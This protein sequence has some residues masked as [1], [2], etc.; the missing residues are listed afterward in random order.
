MRILPC[1]TQ[2]HQHV[3]PDGADET[4]WFSSLGRVFEVEGTPVSTGRFCH[5]V[6]IRAGNRDYYVKRYQARGKHCRKALGRSRPLVEYRNLAYFARMGIP[7]P[8]VV[9]YGSQR[10]L[11]LFRRGAIVTEG[12][13]EAT[14]LETLVRVRPDLL[15]NRT[16]LLQVLRTLADYV[17][18]LHEDGLTH[19]DLKWRNILV[20]TGET[21]N[22]FFLDCP[23]GHHGLGLRREHF[24]VKDLANLDRLARQHLPRTM[25]LRFY[26]WYRNRT[27]LNRKDKRRIAKVVAFWTHRT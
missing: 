22:V 1:G 25:R 8:R 7:V 11:G 5:V 14:D 17:R 18:R 4:E 19:Q 21:P 12:V 3:G 13:L 16:W 10:T 24:I 6:R 23:S 20:T 15:G 9:A 27:R 2:W 26:R